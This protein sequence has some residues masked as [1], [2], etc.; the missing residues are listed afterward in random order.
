MGGWI[1]PSDHQALEL[2]ERRLWYEG[3]KR[4]HDYLRP[5]TGEMSG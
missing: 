3:V 2:Q 1:G 4:W 5:E